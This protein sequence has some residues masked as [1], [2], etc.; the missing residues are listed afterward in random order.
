[1]PS[2]GPSPDETARAFANYARIQTQIANVVADL[3]PPAPQSPAALAQA[4]DSLLSL[5]PKPSV[6]LP[7][8]PADEDM[9]AF[10]AQV[11]QSIARQ[12]AQTRAAHANVSA[13]SVD[14]AT[15]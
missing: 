10:V 3:S 2:G 13:P 15:A 14:A 6:V 12:A 1:M 9:V 8:P 5:L 11:A 4:N 7:L